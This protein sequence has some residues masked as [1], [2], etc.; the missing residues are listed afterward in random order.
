MKYPIVLFSVLC[1]TILPAFSMTDDTTIYTSKEFSI[2]KS[3]VVQGGF[4]ATALS[5]T[6]IKSGYQSP[7]NQSY[8]DVLEF[9]LSINNK[10][11]ELV[12]GINH[13]VRLK[14]V[15]GQV[16]E[17][18]VVFGSKDDTK[19]LEKDKK[20]ILPSNTK[21]RFKVDFSPVLKSF[22]EKGFYE[23]VT[24]EKIYKNE[25]KRLCVAGAIEPLSWDF[26][27]LHGKG[28]QLSD[29]DNDGIFEADIVL[30]QYDPS[31]LT[32]R[33]WKLKNPVAGYPQL[34][35]GSV[36]IDA[37][38]NMSLDETKENIEKDG[39]FRTG[40]EWAGVWTRDLSYSI[41]LGIAAIEPQICKASLMRKV[42]RKRIIQDTG[43]G[44]AWPVSSDREI[45]A[46][47]AFEVYKVTGD[48]AWLKQI[49][50]II[51]NSLE[52]DQKTIVD[53]RTGLMRGESSFLDWRK[54]TYPEWM[55]ASDI[56]SSL[57]LGTNAAHYQACRNLS[58]ISYLLKMEA[59]GKKYADIALKIKEAINKNLWLKDKGYY[60]QYIYGREFQSLSPRSESLGEALCVLYNIPTP[61]QQKSV[62]E[63]TPVVPFGTPCIYPQISGI[64][65]Y[66]NNGVWPFVQ[67]FWNLAAA[68]QQNFN[69]LEHGLAAFYRPAGL[70]LTNKENFVAGSG[71][72][73]GTEVNSDRQ[74]WSVAA[75][76]GMIYK[77]FAGMEFQPDSLMFSPVVPKAYGGTILLSNFKY[78]ASVLDI[79]VK[80]YGSKVSGF[81]VDGKKQGAAV[82]PGNIKG[83]HTIEI[84]LDNIIPAEGK[85]NLVE[86]KFSPGTPD[87]T[88]KN[89]K[90]LWAAIEDATEYV[91][92]VNGTEAE[93]VKTNS[94]EIKDTS[95]AQVI[96]V[97]ALNSSGLESFW[98]APVYAGSSL[99][100][101]FVEAEGFVPKSDL[102]YKGFSGKGF[103]E[104]TRKK[105]RVVSMTANVPEEG[106]YFLDFKYSNGSGP[107]NTE[108][109]CAIR[110]LY[111]NDI[112][113]GVVVLPQIGMDE[114][115]NFG[116]SNLQHLK[117]NKGENKLEL[118]FEPHNEN[119]NVEINAAML[120]GFRLR[121]IK[122]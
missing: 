2:T 115:S 49:Q 85:I 29:A 121:K 120:D 68:K 14:A 94:Y 66:H 102:T 84:Q 60:A 77:L 27:N 113:Q 110:S 58:E 97:K 32:A 93:K 10:D 15:Q 34:R 13:H 108:N 17:I 99:K 95:T 44:G 40:K 118:R 72:Y 18:S 71:D 4:T 55:N 33:E 100:P 42:K 70:F 61:A 21:V 79:T 35:T 117:L 59:D 116:Y 5:P 82:L 88:V 122:Q 75:N 11:N 25:F 111:L 87:V 91:V 16:Q 12:S 83:R 92:S 48:T 90:A 9:K 104:L 86:N 80:G 96:Q 45:W 52:D 3:S 112:Y 19:E 107:Y 69:S 38:Y 1:S 62:I 76:L 98:S 63:N 64:S 36:L 7:A 39:T 109:K 106:E 30:N 101:L 20:K 51:K 8:S 119:M 50:E 37:L 41:L 6:H 78:R 31:K 53:T 103:V 73:R 22:R 67:A 47:A 74:L 43:T 54:Q 56:Y 26:E 57:N 23:C 105:N 81:I 114:W 28:L 65:A 24:G 46:V 89:N